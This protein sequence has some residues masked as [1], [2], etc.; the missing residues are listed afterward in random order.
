MAEEEVRLQDIF[1]MDFMQRF[2]DAF[3]TAMGIAAITVDIHGTPVTQPS[4]FTEFCMKYT[5]GCPK[6]NAGCEQCDADGGARASREGKPQV[7]DCHAGLVDLAAPIMLNGKQVGSILG[8]QVLTH[9]MDEEHIRQKAQEF[10]I[11]PDEY[12]AAAKKTPVVDRKRLEA[13]AQAL[14]LFSSAFSQMGMYNHQLRKLSGNINETT[15][16]VSATMEELAA[17]AR[18]VTDNQAALGTEIKAVDEV[19]SKINEFTKLIENIAKQTKLLGL[20]A[21]IEA[22]RAGTAGA[23]FSVVAE[24]IRKLA[25]SSTDAVAKIQAFTQQISASVQ[26][27]VE[28]SDSTTDIVGQQAEAI[29]QCANS[30]TELTMAAKDL[31]EFAHK[32]E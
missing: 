6:G 2:Q 19:A 17:T 10:G 25:E 7:Y 32:D 12:V 29:E 21:S 8:G 13:A 26:T 3:S 9:P 15:V 1:D 22:A 18:D 20:N 28:K 5:R 30:L 27:T 16:R 31:F 24:E 4:N 14:Y 11:D 23:G